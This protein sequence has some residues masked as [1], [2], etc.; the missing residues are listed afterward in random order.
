M[1]RIL[2]SQ[3]PL[4]CCVRRPLPGIHDGCL[5]VLSCLAGVAAVLLVA[6]FL[7]DTEPDLD[8]SP[9]A[10]PELRVGAESHYPLGTHV[11]RRL[12][13]LNVNASNDTECAGCKS[14]TVLLW[15]EGIG[16]FG[17]DRIYLQAPTT[18]IFKLLTLGGFGVWGLIDFCI[19]VANALS[20]AENIDGLGM[21]AS[22]V[23][24]TVEP[25]RSGGFALIIFESCLW[26]VI[27]PGWCWVLWYL[28]E[29]Q[30]KVKES[31]R[32]RLAKQEKDINHK[33]TGRHHTHSPADLE[34][35]HLLSRDREESFDSDN[36]PEDKQL[37]LRERVCSQGQWRRNGCATM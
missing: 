7:A 28:A 9:E 17:F 16:F 8:V 11:E 2:W 6:I 10:L 18:G 25:A 21:V 34:E 30:S 14:K 3:R 19:V 26:T 32:Q 31:R 29:H 12:Q 27:L 36:Y 37:R 4:R 13:Q 5:L 35:D 15:L 24:S 1:T 22:F 23:P 33:R 20:G